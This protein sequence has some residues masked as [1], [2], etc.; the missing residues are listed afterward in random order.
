M[1]RPELAPVCQYLFT[2]VA[3]FRGQTSLSELTVNVISSHLIGEENKKKRMNQ[4]TNEFCQALLDCGKFLWM[5]SSKMVATPLLAT[6]D[7]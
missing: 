3:R 4:P 2:F 5:R 6:G 1:G 7:S